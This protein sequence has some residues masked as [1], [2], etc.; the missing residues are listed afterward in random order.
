MEKP[1]KTSKIK[2]ETV[3]GETPI[4]ADNS[5]LNVL[6]QEA[7]K[8]GM[9][10]DDANKFESEELLRVTIN[11]LKASQA[12][13]V[14]EVPQPVK[15]DP[16]EAKLDERK[17]KDKAE[18]Q[19][20]YFESQPKVVIMIPLNPTEKPGVIEKKMIN[21]RKEIFV[22]SGA[23]WSK[24]FNGYRVIIPKGVYTEVA[25]DIAKNVSDELNQTL[26]AGDEFKLDRIDPNTG[27]P[28]REQLV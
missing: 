25:K 16:K 18:R 17:W 6:K 22:K 8:L 14:V 5:V 28:V 4:K 21:G 27:R 26:M 3:K 20:A 9:P 15:E 12:S 2:V 23:V 24:S 10:E 13:K 19:R 7:I 1:D 11:T